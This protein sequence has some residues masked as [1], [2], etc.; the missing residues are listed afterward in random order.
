MLCFL[1]RRINR[2]LT[3]R[4]TCICA[5]AFTRHWPRTERALDLLMCWRDRRDHCRRVAV[6]DALDGAHGR[7]WGVA[8]TLPVGREGL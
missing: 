1:S 4:H 5:D 6:W 2:I 8:V 7:G 3:G